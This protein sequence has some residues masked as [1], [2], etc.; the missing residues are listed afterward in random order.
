MELTCKHWD[1]PRAQGIPREDG[2]GLCL[3]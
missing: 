2:T 3:G 1:M